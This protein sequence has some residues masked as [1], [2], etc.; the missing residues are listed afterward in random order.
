ML[1]SRAVFDWKDPLN[2]RSCLTE[3]ERM[4]QDAANAYCQEELLP[5][6]VQRNDG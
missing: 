1:S 6:I 3:E 2:L 4:I 5:G